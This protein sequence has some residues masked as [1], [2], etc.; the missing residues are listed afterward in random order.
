MSPDSG[1]SSLPIRYIYV[2]HPCYDALRPQVEW[3]A[4]VSRRGRYDF[5]VIRDIA[6]RARSVEEARVEALNIVGV[7]GGAWNRHIWRP[8]EENVPCSR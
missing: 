1:V 3:V 2:F 4:R 5:P 6:L 7:V 8:Q